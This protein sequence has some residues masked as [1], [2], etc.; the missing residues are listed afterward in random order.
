MG[1]VNGTITFSRYQIIGTLPD[2]MREFVD[3]QIKLFAFREATA[4]EHEHSVGWTSLENIL[5]TNFEYANYSF[6]EYLAFSLRVDKKVIPPSLLKLKLLQAEKK[7]LSERE[8]KKIFK[9]ERREL[10]ETVR[11]ML[12]QSTPS[13][14][15]FYEV[16]WNVTDKELLFCSHS[17]KTGEEFE[18]LFKRTFNLSLIPILPWTRERLPEDIAANLDRIV[19]DNFLKISSGKS[20]DSSPRD[21]SFLGREFLTWL[22]FKSEER[23]GTILI[24][25]KGDIGLHFTR[26]MVLE[27]GEGQYAERVA[28]Q[29]YYADLKEGITAL[30]KGKKIKEARLKLSVDSNEFEVT[31]KAD[32]FQFQSLKPPP[33]LKFGEEE[34]EKEGRILERVYLIETVIRTMEQLFNLFLSH[35]TS[36]E[37]I[38]SEIPRIQKWMGDS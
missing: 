30:Q 22:W 11:L 8:T 34:E 38:S 1:I 32:K 35:R 36:P 20:V 16:C 7:L 17:Q 2:N 15:S 33:T 19:E 23:G 10:K 14:P 31:L 6:A 26:R 5:D 28:C 9:E 3:A 21:L 25:D 18:D 37:W 29:G 24:P 12:V 27:S 13:T 4:V